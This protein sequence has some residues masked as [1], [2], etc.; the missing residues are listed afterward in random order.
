MEIRSLRQMVDKFRS[1]EL[2][3]S[4][5]GFLAAAKIVGDLHVFTGTIP[6]VTP[7]ELRQIG[8]YLRDN[9]DLT[10]HREDPAYKSWADQLAAYEQEVR[11]M[12]GTSYPK[13][14]EEIKKS[15]QHMPDES[16]ESG[17]KGKQ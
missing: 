4:A 3:R 8:D 1:Q 14:E 12:E 10:D 9:C 2:V 7:D 15:K 5:E 16:E 11:D 13:I 17:T 6:P